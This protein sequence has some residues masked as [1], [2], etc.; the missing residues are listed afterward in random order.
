MVG[1][2]PLDDI[3]RLPLFMANLKNDTLTIRLARSMPS[4]QDSI[5]NF[6]EHDA[7]DPRPRYKLSTSLEV[8]A[9][10]AEVPDRTTVTR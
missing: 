3:G 5:T 9:L 7:S 1:V 2:V 6:C 4:D 8:P 10:E